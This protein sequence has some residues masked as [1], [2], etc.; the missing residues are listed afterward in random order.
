[1][2]PDVMIADERL[3]EV[4]EILATG[5]MR[6]RQ[7]RHLSDHSHLEK[8]SLDFPPD[9]SVHATTGKRRKVAR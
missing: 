7:R 4:A 6:L 3:T 8:N 2:P 9:R 5:L 1:M